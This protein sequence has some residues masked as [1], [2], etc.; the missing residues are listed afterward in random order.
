MK[1]QALLSL[2]DKTKK[3]KVSAAAIF[4]SYTLS[5]ISS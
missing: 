2:N 3:I 4:G 5:E 1:H